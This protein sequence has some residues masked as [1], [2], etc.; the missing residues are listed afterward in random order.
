[1]PI[2]HAFI[3]LRL[4]HQ[5]MIMNKQNN[6]IALITGSNKGIGR[7]VARQ[8]ATLGVTVIATARNEMLGR[9]A[10]EALQSG[11]T[12]I[13]FLQMDVTDE[14]SVKKAAAFVEKEFGRLDILINNAGI[15][16][17]EERPSKQRPSSMVQPSK[18]TAEQLRYT[19][20]VN[21]FGLVRVTSHMLPVL[22]HSR[23]GRIVNVSSPLG[24]LALRANPE[25]LIAKVGLI[26]YGSSKAAVNSIT[27]HYA[28]E[29]RGTNILVNAANP[30]MVATDLNTHSGHRTVE[31]GAKIIIELATLRDD[32]PT[33]TFV[34]DEGI[35]PW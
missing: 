9:Q 1:M 4:T 14:N 32:G 34:G 18:I 24:S 21:V 5:S 20:E 27:L 6:R 11:Q 2:A 19:Y 3:L 31:E 8:L 22:R 29:L 17:D 10:V 23:E 15:I 16:S 26:A 13:R 25:N 12:D 7:E 30:G 35:V 28:N 33:G